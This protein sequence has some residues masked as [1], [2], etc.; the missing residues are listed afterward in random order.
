MM[1]AA[2]GAAVQ[3]GADRWT[4]AARELEDGPERDACWSLAAAVYP[5]FDSYHQ[6]TERRIPVAVLERRAA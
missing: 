5:G 2:A 3:V 4:V 1:L 6:F